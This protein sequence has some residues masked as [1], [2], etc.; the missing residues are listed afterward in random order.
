MPWLVSSPALPTCV[1]DTLDQALWHGT[2]AKAVPAT[3]AL[4][5]TG[6]GFVGSVDWFGHRT[7]TSLGVVDLKRGNP[8]VVVEVD[9]LP[10]VGHV[11]L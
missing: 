7:L 11:W 10:A 8:Q 2:I 4:P 3:R 9:I 6:Q 1:T 5:R